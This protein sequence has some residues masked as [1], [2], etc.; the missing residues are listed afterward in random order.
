M[1]PSEETIVW[2]GNREIRSEDIVYIRNL[3]Q[4]FRK[5]SRTELTYTLCEHLG[6]LTPAGAPKYNA[7]TKLLARL[8]ASGEICLPPRRTQG[9]RPTMES[10]TASTRIAAGEPLQCSLA[11][12]PPVR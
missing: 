10:P 11:D 2:Q 1:S 7:C 8:E 6:W 4:R 3:I 12:L 9:G 5:F